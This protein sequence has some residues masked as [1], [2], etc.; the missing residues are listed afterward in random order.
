[1]DQVVTIMPMVA[2]DQDMVTGLH[3]VTML[4][5]YHTT[6]DHNHHHTTKVTIRIDTSLMLHGVLEVTDLNM[7]TEVPEV[8]KAWLLSLNIMVNK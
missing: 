6:V 4:L 1:M 8:V 2:V 3:M 5:E 7:V